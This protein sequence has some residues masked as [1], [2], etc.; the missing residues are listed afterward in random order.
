MPEIGQAAPNRPSGPQLD[1]AALRRSS[2]ILNVNPTAA[3]IN[4]TAPKIDQAVAN[5]DQ[6]AYW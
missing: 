4:Q 3:K 5:T 6:A 2:P 1:Q